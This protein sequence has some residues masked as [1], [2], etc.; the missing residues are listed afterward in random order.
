MKE[1]SLSYRVRFDGTRGSLIIPSYA[2]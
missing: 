2:K 1:R